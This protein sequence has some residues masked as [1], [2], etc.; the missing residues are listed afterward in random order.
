MENSKVTEILKTFSGH[1]FNVFEKYLSSSYLNPYPGVLTL[2]LQLK[3]AL[4]NGKDAPVK[5][6]IYKSSQQEKKYDDKHMRYL[7]SFLTKYLE[8]FLTDKYL[9]KNPLQYLQLKQSALA[10]RD[11]EKAYR[12]AHDEFHKL[13]ATRSTLEPD[14]YYRQFTVAYQQL[15]YLSG[16]QKRKKILRF[17][18]VM[19]HLDVFYISKKL[20]LYCEMINAQN[21]LAAEYK[22]L[23]MEEI[24]KE[25]GK[26]TFSNV[27]AI[28]V[29]YYILL[30]LTDSDQEKYFEELK[31]LLV[32]HAEAFP[33][34]ELNDLY[35]YLK[36]YCIKKLNRGE[37]GYQQKLFEIYKMMLADKKLMKADYLSQWEYKN[38]VTLSLRLKENKWT[39]KF[40]ENFNANLP[41]AARSNAYTYNTANWVFHEKDYNK[42]LKLLQKVNFTD[43]YYQLDSRAILLKTYFETDDDE[44]FFYQSGAFK[45]FLSRNKM[46]SDYQRII[47]RNFV[48]YATRLVR[49]GSNQKKLSLIK[50]ELEHLK[51]VADKNW[52]LEKIQNLIRV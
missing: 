33:A 22:A 44:S 17:D 46:I 27:P 4:L 30:T 29:Y 8:D 20:Q 9:Q 39:R 43:I 10:E 7:I 35:Q 24:K 45:T 52:L 49:M 12:F 5:E 19:H 2:F 50:N 25:A 32:K 21:V 23:F 42:A 3:D 13:S 48:K 16:K 31:Q 14:Y 47:Y 28:N 37:A 34:R 36:N 38:I 51:E 26:N 6:K 15:S 41:P 18:E 40:I 11:C 1:D